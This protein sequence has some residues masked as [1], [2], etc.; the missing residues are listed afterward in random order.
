M[1]SSLALLLAF[2]N[3]ND[4]ETK[5]KKKHPSHP[6]SSVGYIAQATRATSIAV[7]SL[8][9]STF[10]SFV[11][12]QPLTFHGRSQYNRQVKRG[13]PR[14]RTCSLHRVRNT[15]ESE[16]G[17]ALVSDR[18]LI[19]WMTRGATPQR[20]Y[21]QRGDEKGADEV[22]SKRGRKTNRGEKDNNERIDDVIR[23]IPKTNFKT[24]VN[25]SHWSNVTVVETVQG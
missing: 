25:L 12:F 20:F 22:K 2:P 10:P 17:K 9:S 18:A 4:I 15:G 3:T 14:G 19:L 13:R 11:G 24:Y 23:A 8:S 6:G 1:F 21:P 16:H 7:I 5:N